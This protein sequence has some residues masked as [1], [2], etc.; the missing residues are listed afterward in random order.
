M[1]S[2]SLSPRTLDKLH[3]ESAGTFA[4]LIGNSEAQFRPQKEAEAESLGG[5]GFTSV[6]GP[7]LFSA[8]SADTSPLLLSGLYGSKP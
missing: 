5:V 1:N 2:P 7:A 6:C 4:F 3:M 8:L